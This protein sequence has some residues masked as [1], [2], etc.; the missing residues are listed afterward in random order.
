MKKAT[1]YVVLLRNHDGGL[2][3]PMLHNATLPQAKEFSL[4]WPG[5]YAQ[6]SPLLPG[7]LLNVAWVKDGSECPPPPWAAAVLRG[8]S[9]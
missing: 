9:H 5:C 6:L 2:M 8:G 1:T 3:T 4:D 7:Q